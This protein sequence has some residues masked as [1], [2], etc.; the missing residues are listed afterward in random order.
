MLI[1]NRNSL[2]LQPT[3]ADF[4]AK[5]LRSI[6]MIEISLASILAIDLLYIAYLLIRF[7]NKLKVT[8]FN[9]EFKISRLL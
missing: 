7:S 3:I 2:L 5:L 6:A 9:N 1:V 4:T 8:R